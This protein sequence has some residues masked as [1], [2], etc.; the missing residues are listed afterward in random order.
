MNTHPPQP[1]RWTDNDLHLAI[2]L[3]WQTGRDYIPQGLADAIDDAKRTAN[4]GPPALTYEERIALRLVDIRGGTTTGRDYR[5]GPIPWDTTTNPPAPTAR[6]PATN[7]QP[8]WAEGDWPAVHRDVTPSVW[9]RIWWD[10]DQA[11][12]NRHPNLEPAA[13]HTLGQVTRQ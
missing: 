7:G 13:A 1:P 4:T 5:G 3:A 11:T 9:W 8:I 10:L 12:R 2:Q 6:P